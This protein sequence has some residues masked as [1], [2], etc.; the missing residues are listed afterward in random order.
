M[1]TP[2]G[3]VTIDT[4]G[5]KSGRGAYVS[6]EPA[7]IKKAQTN[8]SLDAALGVSVDPAFYDELFAYVDHQKSTSRI[9]WKKLTNDDNNATSIKL[10]WFKFTC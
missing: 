2:D 5:K 6:L 4:T 3:N 9:I 1:R 8:K 10:N 7:L